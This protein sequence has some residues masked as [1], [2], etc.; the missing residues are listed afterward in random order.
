MQKLRG[1]HTPVLVEHYSSTFID[2]LSN[3][4][5]LRLH[6]KV[7]T[8]STT[9]CPATKGF[10]VCYTEVSTTFLFRPFFFLRNLCT[11]YI[12]H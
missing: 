5:W 2:E 4:R 10:S 7:R 8:K 12:K 9:R 3:Y 6:Y 11:S 1:I